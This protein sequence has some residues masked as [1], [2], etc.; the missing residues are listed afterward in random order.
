MSAS[1]AVELQIA[2][3]THGVP[4]RDRIRAWIEDTIAHAGRA[5]AGRFEVVVRVVDERESR[6]LNYRFRHKDRP[7]NVLAFPASMPGE[8]GT[9][10]DGESMPLGDLAVC[11]PVLDREAALQGKTAEAHWAHL[12]VHGTLHLLGYDHESADDAAQM[13]ALETRILAARGIADPYA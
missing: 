10:A 6:A 4:P 7:T 3:R 2:C 9:A 13:E 8:P 5:A 1:V 12:V 11:A